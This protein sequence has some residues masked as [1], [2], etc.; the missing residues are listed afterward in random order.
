MNYAKK[1]FTVTSPGT[2][3]YG[4]NWEKTFRG[5]TN[6]QAILEDT[7]GLR[8]YWSAGT[9]TNTQLNYA[10]VECRK[11]I[12]FSGRCDECA[13]HPLQWERHP[14]SNDLSLGFCNY[15]AEDACN[16]CGWL[17]SVENRKTEHRCG[18]VDLNGDGCYL[19]AVG[20]FGGGTVPHWF[21]AAHGE[22]YIKQLYG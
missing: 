2:Q 20:D 17:K 9:I 21:C 13:G 8:R 6:D 3:S 19:N 11:P 7:K 1:S 10:C 22:A 15:L 16:K 18:A 14:K 5:Q 12:A 4:E